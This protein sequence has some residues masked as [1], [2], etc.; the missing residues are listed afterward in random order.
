MGR[1]EPADA[2]HDHQRPR[3]LIGRARSAPVPSVRGEAPTADASLSSIR[4]A[5]SSSPEAVTGFRA[6]IARAASAFSLGDLEVH[7]EAASGPTGAPE[8]GP[9]IRLGFGG[10]AICA[11]GFFLRDRRGTSH[12]PN[13]SFVVARSL[14]KN[15]PEDPH[16]APPHAP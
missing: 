12:P 16:P 14:G 8:E 15:R 13:G 6:P 2:S 4:S 3:K 10:Q 7:N 1:V 11:S 9:R 5:E